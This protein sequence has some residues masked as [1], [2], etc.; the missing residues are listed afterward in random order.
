MGE[1]LKLE[2]LQVSEGALVNETR[3]VVELTQVVLERCRRQEQLPDGA[4]SE[5]KILIRLS[6]RVPKPVGLIEDRQV[7]GN[8]RHLV[9]HSVGI[10]VRDNHDLGLGEGLCGSPPPEPIVLA[11]VEDHAREVELERQFLLPLLA[12]GCGA[13]D[14]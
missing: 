9:L 6:T 10:M 13:D 11:T 4:Q 12:D 8:Q 2:R 14:K 7:P 3:Q 5:P 1:Y